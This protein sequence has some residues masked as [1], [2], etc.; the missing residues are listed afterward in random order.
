MAPVE[1]T[2]VGKTYRA[3]HNRFIA[4]HHSATF[5]CTM[6]QIRVAIQTSLV[7]L[8]ASSLAAC[9]RSPARSSAEVHVFVA[10]SLS[11][12]THEIARDFEAAHSSVKIVVS[13]GATGRLFQ[14]ISSGAPCDVF[15]PADPGFVDRLITERLALAGD[16]RPL[17]SNRLVVI[18]PK[19]AQPESLPADLPTAFEIF[20]GSIAI[21]S[22]DHA[23]AGRYARQALTRSRL[24]EQLQP[25]LRYADDVRFAAR[26][27]AERAVDAG[28]VYDSDALAMKPEVTV[29]YA[30]AAGEHDP[31]RY[32]GVVLESSASA[33]AARRFLEFAASTAARPVWTRFGFKP[34]VT[35]GGESAN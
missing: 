16:V 13:H 27:V 29:V 11:D 6:K 5:A 3:N 23:P 24:W 25:R 9:D 32:E 10:A 15:I 33:D 7:L 20:R 19:S 21:A 1:P 14:Q 35:A 17:A 30:C 2:D 34:P 22:P 18:V 31:I 12:V 28:I 26:Y 4:G 8:A